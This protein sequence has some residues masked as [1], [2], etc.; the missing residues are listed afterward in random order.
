LK[1]SGTICER[2]V[3]ETLSRFIVP[4]HLRL[5]SGF[6]AT[7]DLLR[8]NANLPQCDILIVDRNAVPLFRL[9][10]SGIEVV[11]R[12]SVC[13]II[14]VKRS[15]TRPALVGENSSLRHLA[16]IV[17]SLG[18]TEALKTD[19][20]LNL[21]N[22]GIGRH[23]HSSDKPLL[24]VVALRN[25]LANFNDVTGWVTEENSLVDFLWTLD[26][27]SL[28]PSFYDGETLLYYSHTARPRTVTWAKLTAEEFVAAESPFYRVFSGRPMWNALSPAAGIDRAS[29]FAKII[30]VVSLMIS[31]VCAR[32]LDEGH[33]N[34]YYLR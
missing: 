16:S 13:G 24:G 32:P 26:G 18:E 15:L 27:C 30:G 12:E 11:P 1:T 7:P 23:N 28:L 8:T 25:G 33:I 5:T 3:R 34:E 21:F 17:E 22:L 10:G 29:V 14:E 31:R 4:G 19:A 20:K 9:D 6:I 2:F